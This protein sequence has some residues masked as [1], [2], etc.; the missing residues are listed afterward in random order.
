[1]IFTGFDS[2]IA[3]PSFTA[4]FLLREP[5][6]NSLVP[7]DT[8]NATHP[9]IGAEPMEVPRYCAGI[10]LVIDRIR[11]HC[12][13]VAPI[14]MIAGIILYGYPA[15]FHHDRCDRCHNEKYN[16]T[17]YPN[18]HKLWSISVMDKITLFAPIFL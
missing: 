3:V 15:Q 10:I 14:K 12:R 17:R 5:C 8:R 13:T 7:K 18:V 6:N 2:S 11:N 16:E 9:R 4:A 1:M